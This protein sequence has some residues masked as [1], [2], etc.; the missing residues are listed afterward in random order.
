MKCLATRSVSVPTYD[1]YPGLSPDD[2]TFTVDW[3]NVRLD[4]DNLGELILRLVNYLPELDISDFQKRESGG[5]CFYKEGIHIPKIGYSSFV[6]AFNKDLN[7][8]IKNSKGARGELYGVL[9][10]ISGDGCRF[11][12]S[13]HDNA[14]VHFLEAISIYHPECSRIDLACDIFDKNNMLVPMIHTFASTAYDREHALVDLNCNLQRVDK[15]GKLRQ[16]VKCDL[17]YDEIVQDFTTNVTVGGRASKKG[18]LQLYNKRAEILGRFD[19]DR[20]I[21]EA[22]LNA[23]GNPDYWW[24]LEYRCKS[25]AQEVFLNLCESK[26]V[27]SAFLQ[28]AEGF[29]RFVSPRYDVGNI[30]KADDMVEWLVFLDF[31]RACSSEDIHLVQ[32]VS[33][34]YIPADVSRMEKYCCEQIPAVLF[35]NSLRCTLDESYRNRVIAKGYQALFRSKRHLKKLDE[36][37]QMYGYK[38]E[39]FLDLC[40]EQVGFDIA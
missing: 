33:D 15:D 7:G 39:E 18:T 11:I 30:S 12:N 31:I 13:L 2:Y 28:A 3:L 19:S 36:L 29:G 25:Y 16:W 27:Y 24:R 32:L 8:F 1:V 6:I 38:L 26:N 20:E 21:K 4:C 37:R 22:I 23:H 14:F 34:K 5:V 40:Y 35:F 9:I 17:V 10:S